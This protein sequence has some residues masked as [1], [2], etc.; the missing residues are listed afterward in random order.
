[1]TDAL[2][3]ELGVPVNAGTV[4]KE[5]DGA[6]PPGAEPC[7]AVAAGLAVEEAPR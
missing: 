2:S 3:S 6:V 7:V 4:A 5:H 1:M